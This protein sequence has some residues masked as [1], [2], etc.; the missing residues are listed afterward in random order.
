MRSVIEWLLQVTKVTPP[1]LQLNEKEDYGG[2]GDFFPL[3]ELQNTLLYMTH[4]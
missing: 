2:M 4:L 3:K 1:I